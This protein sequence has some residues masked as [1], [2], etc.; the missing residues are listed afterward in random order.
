MSNVSLYRPI[1]TGWND[2]RRTVV[3][4]KDIRKNL[5]C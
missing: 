5:L 3:V 4:T 1:M 2:L